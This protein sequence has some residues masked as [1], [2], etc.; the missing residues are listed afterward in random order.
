MLEKIEDYPEP[1]CHPEHNPPMHMVL[2]P[3]KY[4]HTCPACGYSVT[5][6]VPNMSCESW[7]LKG[8]R[9]YQAIL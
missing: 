1:C 4:R 5:F 3:G 7:A 2:G 8:G 6:E 9:D